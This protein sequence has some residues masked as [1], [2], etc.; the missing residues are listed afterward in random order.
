MRSTYKKVSGM[1]AEIKIRRCYSCGNILQSEDKF[2]PGFV[3]KKR[4]GKDEGLCDRCY[5]LRHPVEG[6]NQTLDNE[7]A[8]LLTNA[9]NAGALFCYVFD[10]FAVDASIVPGLIEIIGSNILAIFTKR[11]ILPQNVDD[12]EIIEKF[13][14][15]LSQNGINPKAII[16]TSAYQAFDYENFLST[17][18]KYRDGKDVF[19]V[20]ASQVGKSALINN[21]LM[22]YDNETGR[23]ITSERIG[24]E[25]MSLT[26]I[27][28]D[29]SSTLF[30]TPG[31]FNPKSLLNQVER[32]TLKYIVPH[33][34]VVAVKENIKSGES[35]FLG[36]LGRIDNI[37]DKVIKTNLYFARDV[38]RVK[39]KIEKAD[40]AFTSLVNSEEAKPASLTV[41]SISDLEKHRFTLP[42]NAP[43]YI[44][45]CG[46][47]KISIEK[48]EGQDIDVFAPK[49]VAVNLFTDSAW[50]DF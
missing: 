46:Y 25:G 39:S 7:F 30:D 1:T 13:K 40:S 22:N 43:C 44:S 11:D 38:V 35:I 14:A 34:P 6:T 27:P 8:S 47:G 32:R 36:G 15:Q 31:I 33:V 28:L 10:S 41:K 16:L 4:A 20:G 5:D 12:K 18:E 2:E 37:S 23:N 50:L 42:E 17:I 19:F 3:S 9:K 24:S 21:I 26:E 48:G 45:I 29:K 49:G